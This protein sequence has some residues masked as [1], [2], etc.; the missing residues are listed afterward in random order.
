VALQDDRNLFPPYQLA[1][2]VR[3]AAIEAEPKIETVANRVSALVDNGVMCR[4]NQQVEVGKEKPRDVA[5]AFLKSM[6]IVR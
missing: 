6:G 3:M 5:K 4:L 2:A 1:P